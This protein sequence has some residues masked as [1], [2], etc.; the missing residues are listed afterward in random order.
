MALVGSGMVGPGQAQFF[1]VVLQS[2][3]TYQVYVKPVDYSVD[4]DL[5]IYDER[6]NL[7]ARDNTTAPDAYCNITPLW[8]GPFRLEVK[9]ERGM[10]PFN[11]V[12]QA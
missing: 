6:G 3:V 1:D 8:T 11:I 5:Y 2:G 9:S 4:F 12:V 7:V 10:S